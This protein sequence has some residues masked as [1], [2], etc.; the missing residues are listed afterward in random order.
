MYASAIENIVNSEGFR[1]RVNEQCIND[2]KKGDKR[3]K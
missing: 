1:K 3:Y 2:G